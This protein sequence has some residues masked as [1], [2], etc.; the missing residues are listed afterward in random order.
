MGRDATPP[1]D[2]GLDWSLPET[3]TT[4]TVFHRIVT[5]KGITS[6]VDVPTAPVVPLPVTNPPEPPVQTFP[7]SPQPVVENKPLPPDPLTGIPQ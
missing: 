6:V 4:P 3:S 5:K 7:P 2:I 1:M